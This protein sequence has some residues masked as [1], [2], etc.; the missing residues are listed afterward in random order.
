M[1][2]KGGGGLVIAVFLVWHAS[3]DRTHRA[4]TRMLAFVAGCAGQEVPTDFEH[5][6]ISS[7]NFLRSIHAIQDNANMDLVAVK[8]MFTSLYF[9]SYC[10]KT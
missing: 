3:R 4:T 1:I 8:C 6:P 7:W 9:V 2:T 10:H 5:N